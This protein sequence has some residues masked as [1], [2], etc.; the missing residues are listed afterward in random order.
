MWLN[1]GMYYAFGG[2]YYGVPQPYGYWS[3][4]GVPFYM[5]GSS[6]IMNLITGKY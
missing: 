4:I 3:L 6:R 2:W 1:I 5:A